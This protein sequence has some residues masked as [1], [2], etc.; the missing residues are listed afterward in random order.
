MLKLQYKDQR[1]PA[2]WL[3]EARYA[4]G[5]DPQN[6]VVLTEE[7][8]SPF[9]AEI[10]VEGE[11]VFISDTGSSNGTFVNGKR[12]Q[13][14]TE[15]RASD[16][17][18][19]HKVEFLLLD[20]KAA[21][22]PAPDGATAISPALSNIQIAAAGAR[23]ESPWALKAKTGSLAGQAFA[24]PVVGKLVIGRATN[25]DIQLPANS[26]SRQHAEVQ[27]AG[28][29][30]V[31][32]DLNSSNGTYVNR[33]KVAESELKPGDEVR[34]DTF[35]FEVT[36][37]AAA[38]GKTNSAAPVSETAARVAASAPAAASKTPST[39]SSTRIAPKAETPAAVPAPAAKAGGGNGMLVVVAL[40]V[41]VA[42][43][44]G[45]FLLK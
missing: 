37:Q 27:V 22:T 42:A 32:R 16:V 34:F 36:G 41:V 2:I 12:I 45:W 6:T 23:K 1:K 5:K 11:Q 38:A 44:A 31:V 26:V 3:V 7:G 14:R 8:V 28:D 25:C 40:L 10:R 4:I 35:S 13:R 43:A 18:A 9:H 39:T 21:A 33:K 29:K 24:V 19:I 17:I 30:L 20:P 15:L